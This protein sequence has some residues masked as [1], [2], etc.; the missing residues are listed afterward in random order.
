MKYKINF[1]LGIVF[2]IYSCDGLNNK[3][4]YAE[5]QEQIK[6]SLEL[7][8]E[9]EASDKYLERGAYA[10]WYKDSSGME[11]SP[12]KVLSAKMIQ[13]ENS[14]FKSI[15]LIYK[16]VSNKTIS[17]I[18]FE[19]YGENAFGEPADMGSSHGKGGGF[20][21]ETMKP[22]ST[23]SGVWEILNRDGKKVILAR[24]H[25]VVFADG[26]KWHLNKK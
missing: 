13:P 12:V 16:N 18:K 21:D 19:W 1:I 15:K 22:N 20:T 3:A 17:A 8:K 6:D 2:F 14:N 9:R 26:S 5:R 25:E 23:K 11:N 4:K 7:V 10:P 24:A